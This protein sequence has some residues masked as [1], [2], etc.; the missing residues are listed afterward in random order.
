M[1]YQ[2]IY[3]HVLPVHWNN[4][5]SLR[6]TATALRCLRLEAL[7]LA[8]DA[9]AS[10]YEKEVEFSDDVWLQRLQNLQARHLVATLK[11]NAGAT[12]VNQVTG[13]EHTAKWIGLIVVMEKHGSERASASIPPWT[14][15][16]SQKTTNSSE[17]TKEPETAE[18]P[19]R[20]YQLHGLFVHP[21]VRRRGLGRALIKES[22]KYIKTRMIEQ[23]LPFARVD[24]L[25]D[26]W[27]SSA[28]KLYLSCG[29]EFVSQDSYNVGE[30][31]R[32]ALS[33]SVVLSTDK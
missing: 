9:Y 22:Y 13:L 18:D 28:K 17:M 21:S 11:D 3:F 6:E 7:Q 2:G 19:T 1:A 24:V 29:F 31:A 15:N 30:S 33:L 12:E 8:P 23:G 4:K 32:T 14:Y 20:F 27:N 25:V 10:T 26:S 16:A 5:E